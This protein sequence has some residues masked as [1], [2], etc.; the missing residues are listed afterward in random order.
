M[1][2]SSHEK[3]VRLDVSM[4]E[5]VVVEIFEATNHLEKKDI[6]SI[7]KWTAKLKETK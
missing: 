1:F 7:K 5:I 4:N 2:S 3:V 6:T